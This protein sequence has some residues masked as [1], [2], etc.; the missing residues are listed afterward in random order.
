[1]NRK[2]AILSI[3][4]V[5]GGA[6]ALYSGIAFRHLYTSPDL[7][8]LDRKMD[9]LADLVETLIPETDTPGARTAGVHITVAHFVRTMA[10]RKT[11][12]IFIAGLQET[13]DCAES[14]Y[15]LPFTKLNTEQRIRVVATLRDN[16]KRSGGITGKLKDRLLGK[17]F[18]S[19]LKDYTVQAFC[20]SK[21]GATQVLAYDYIPGGYQACVARGAAQRAWATK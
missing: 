4:A 15:Q 20:T 3:I 2:K 13:E 19:V 9:L 12:N 17:P 5:G 16:G 7:S 8:V 11:Q 18:F 14:I 21:A 1:M 10:D 6:G